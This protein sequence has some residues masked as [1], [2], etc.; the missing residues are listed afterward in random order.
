VE[1][2]VVPLSIVSGVQIGITD[3]SVV[4]GVTVEATS[5]DVTN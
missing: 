1:S 3:A 4:D 5:D 2:D